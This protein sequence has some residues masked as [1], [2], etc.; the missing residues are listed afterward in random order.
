VPAGW[1]LVSNGVYPNCDGGPTGGFTVGVGQTVVCAFMDEKLGTIVIQKNAV[2][3]GDATFGFTG[4]GTGGFPASFSI[5]TVN[6]VGSQTFPDIDPNNTYSVSESQLP[7]P[8]WVLA[9]AGCDQGTPGSFTVAPG[10]TTTCTF[11]NMR[12]ASRVTNSLLCFFDRDPSLAGNQFRLI[13]TQDPQAP[14]TYK[15]TASNPGQFYYNVFVDGTPGDA[16]SVAL[17]IPYPF[18]TQGANPVHE[19]DGAT[20]YSNNNCIQPG[21]DVSSGFTTSPAPPITL[22]SY[23]PQSFGSNVTLTVSGTIPASG[24]LYVNIHLDFGLKTQTGYTKGTASSCP[25]GAVQPPD[26]F[27]SLADMYR[28]PSLIVAMARTCE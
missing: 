3:D 15:L 26:A 6:H 7:S 20:F 12:Q 4:T 5:T 17:T 27:T 28:A 24:I 16:V 14:N 10:S 2:G 11:T 9:G 13:F 1:K 21:T 25:T 23:G 18:V 19:Y 22:G 8:L